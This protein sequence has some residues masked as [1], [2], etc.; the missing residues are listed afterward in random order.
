MTSNENVQLIKVVRFQVLTVGS[1]DIKASWD[2][3]AV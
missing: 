2:I 3:G 1:M